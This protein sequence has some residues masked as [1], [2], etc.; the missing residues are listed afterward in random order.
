LKSRS[1]AV[2]CYPLS[3]AREALAV[4]RREFTTLLVGAAIGW[5]LS[6]RAQQLRIPTHSGQA[7]RFDAGHRS[8]MKPATVPI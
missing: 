7:Y 5:P 1:A 3:G 4:E 2:L 8:E 6:A